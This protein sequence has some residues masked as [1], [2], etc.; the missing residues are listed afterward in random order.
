MNNETKKCV[1]FCFGLNEN[2]ILGWIVS[3]ERII[4]KST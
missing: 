4:L 1:P 3:Y 2:K